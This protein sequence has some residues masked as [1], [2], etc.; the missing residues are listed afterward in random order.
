MDNFTLL[1]YKLFSVQPKFQ[2]LEA[3]DFLGESKIHLLLTWHT[4]QMTLKQR[5]TDSVNVML[6]GY[7]CDVGGI[8]CDQILDNT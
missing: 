8:C 7:E 6:V 5:L 1:Y 4:R 2:S 3:V